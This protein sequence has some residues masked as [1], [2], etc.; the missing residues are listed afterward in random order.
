MLSE[1]TRNEKGLTVRPHLHVI[2]EWTTKNYGV[3]VRMVVISWRW[4]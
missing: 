3:E 1:C 4:N 2:L